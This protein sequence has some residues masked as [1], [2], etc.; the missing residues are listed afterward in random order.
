MFAYYI[1][2]STAL[3]IDLLGVNVTTP[4]YSLQTGQSVA[5]NSSAINFTPGAQI[6]WSW[7]TTSFQPQ[8]FVPGCANLTSCTYAPPKSGKM[9]VC[10]YDENNHAVCGEGSQVWVTAW[11]NGAPHCRVNPLPRYTRI[12]DEYNVVDPPTHKVAHLGRDY[13]TGDSTP[14]YAPDSGRVVY[15]GWGKSAGFAV[16]VRSSTP[17][18][19][20]LLLD[21]YFFHLMQNIV[22]HEGQ[23]VRAG[24]LLAFSDNSGKH[25][26]GTNSSTGPHLHFEQHIQR[27][28]PA[29]GA[30]SLSAFPFHYAPHETAIVPCTF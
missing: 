6:A 10:M 23:V 26:D 21:T 2:G 17:D 28:W 24:Q 22:V 8:I 15:S 5:L 11:T 3:S 7:D 19:R 13:A 27:H 18:A 12:S 16:V 30:D 14:V 4:A 1:S 9:Q 29:A 20:G 25:E